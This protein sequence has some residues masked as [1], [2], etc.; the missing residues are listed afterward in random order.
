MRRPIAGLVA[1]L[2]SGCGSEPPRLAVELRSVP[3]AMLLDGVDTFVFSVE[4]RDG[5]PLLLRRSSPAARIQLDS[6]PHGTQLTF[7]L[8]GLFRE[9]PIVRGR[10]CPIDVLE[11]QPLPAVSMFVSRAGSF[12]RI[13]DPPGEVRSAPLL[14]VRGDGV[15]VAA[16]GR[17]QAG[18]A[19]S[20]TTAFDPRTGA[21]AV[22]RPLGSAR[23][24]GAVAS[25]DEGQSALLVGGEDEAGRSVDRFERYQRGSGFVPVS[26][27]AGFGGAGVMATALPDGRVLVTG[28]AEGGQPARE[29]AALFGGD[30]GD[31]LVRIAPMAVPRRAH[32]VS[33]VGAGAFA[34]AFVLGGDGGSGRPAI[35]LIETYNPRAVSASFSME[36]AK[37]AQ[38][39]AEHSATTLRTGEILVAGGRATADLPLASAEVFDP[40][41]RS[42]TAAGSLAHARRRHTATLLPDGRVLITGGLGDDGRPL[43]SAE[44]YDPGARSFAAARPL[45][46]ERADH[47]AVELCD[48]TVLIVGGAPGAEI[49]N[50]T[51]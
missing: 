14:F 13:D 35:D 20:S 39:R 30:R 45:A 17:G 19:L 10:S 15:V 28:G 4:D 49:Y 37:L 11:G 23:A 21:W 48:G 8:E 46:Q 43:R 51:R 2:M 7:R 44:L 5:R 16:G 31:N 29:D 50:P 27:A 22:E 41:T 36:P 18:Q 24:G 6:I 38:A 3:G 32:T 33:V 40:I 47:A 1:L 25:L 26:G 42:V 9:A 12:S 34:A